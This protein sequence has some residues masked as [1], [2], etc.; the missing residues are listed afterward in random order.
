MT[1]N[2]KFMHLCICGTIDHLM[3]LLLASYTICHKVFETGIMQIELMCTKYIFV[4]VYKVHF[5][6]KY[7]LSFFFWAFHLGT[8]LPLC[9]FAMEVLHD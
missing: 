9:F 3:V 7:Y 1:K 6:A 2:N 8:I 5:Y 4:D